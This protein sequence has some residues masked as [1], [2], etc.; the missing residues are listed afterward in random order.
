ME[1]SIKSP[2]HRCGCSST[3]RLWRQ[4]SHGWYKSLIEVC[5]GSVDTPVVCVRTLQFVEEQRTRYLSNYVIYP[6]TYL[7]TY[8]SIHLSMYLF[9]CL[10][11]YLTYRTYLVRLTY[12]SHLS[13]CLSIPPSLY[14][15][16]CISIYLSICLSV[17]LSTQSSQ[18]LYESIDRS[19][20]PS[21]QS[22][23]SIH[24]ISH[25]INI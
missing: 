8:L 20:R 3:E 12:L 10:S 24:L 15:S 1:P 19:I 4:S 17:Y 7:A 23:Y 6:P 18:L 14:L 2:M 11:I 21:C 9:V 25:S 22:F 16:I 5:T 13:V